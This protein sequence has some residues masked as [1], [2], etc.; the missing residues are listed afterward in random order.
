MTS[1]E[2]FEELKM[3]FVPMSPSTKARAK[4]ARSHDS[5]SGS[6]RM[7]NGACWPSKTLKVKSGWK[8]DKS[9]G[10]ARTSATSM[11]RLLCRLPHRPGRM[12]MMLKLMV[13]GIKMIVAATPGGSK[14]LM[15]SS[16]TWT[17]VE[18]T[19]PGLSRPFGVPP[20]R[21]RRRSKKPTPLM[22]TR[23]VPSPTA[24]P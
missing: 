12:V 16:T 3:N 20:R 4:V 8:M 2:H 1:S 18:L 21:S 6:S 9:I 14:K 17:M 11:P 10:L 7:V 13:F 5:T 19:G 15:A 24:G 22:R 23:S